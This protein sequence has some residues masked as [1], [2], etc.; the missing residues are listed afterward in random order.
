MEAVEFCDLSQQYLRKSESVTSQPTGYYYNTNFGRLASYI[1]I[2]IKEKG[3][4]EM[5]TTSNVESHGGR[6]LSDA[7]GKFGD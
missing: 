4:H 1:G 6:F 2:L 3:M 7:G 5:Y